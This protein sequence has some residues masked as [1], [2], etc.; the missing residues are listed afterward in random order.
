MA[1]LGQKQD[2]GLPRGEIRIL[3]D[4]RPSV[5]KSLPNGYNWLLKDV[6]DYNGQLSK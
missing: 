4:H 3:L 5:S 2:T 6:A 1:I